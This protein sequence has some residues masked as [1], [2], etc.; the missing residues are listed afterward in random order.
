VSP[1]AAPAPLAPCPSSRP[2]GQTGST[3]TLERLAAAQDVSTPLGWKDT[4]H[5]DVVGEEDAI[6]GETDVTFDESVD[7]SK[8]SLT[9]DHRPVS[10]AFFFAPPR[11]PP[12]ADTPLANTARVGRILDAE[13]FE[14][15][16]TPGLVKLVIDLG[17]EEV[18][19][20]AQL[21]LN[22]DLA[23]LV[24]RQVLCVT[25]LG[26]VDIAGFESQ[27]LTVGVPGEDGDP[28]LVAPDRDVPLGGTLY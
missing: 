14:E 16:R 21:A 22:Y 19:S 23:E 10:A 27:V 13:P 1:T 7:G 25:D 28:V 3:T 2:R 5:L 6:V 12:M 20:A 8:L 15:A 17:D 4:H 9:V 26:T 11:G 18:R 24:G